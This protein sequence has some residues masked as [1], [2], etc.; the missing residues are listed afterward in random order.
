TS[1]AQATVEACQRFGKPC[2]PLY[3]A[4]SFEPSHVA[5]WIAQNNVK[6]LNVA[7][8]REHDEPGIGHRVERFLDEVLEQLG[9][10][11]V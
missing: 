4:A 11:R 10:R 6:T 1:G 3:P 8:N 7:G 5:D 2:L 9:H